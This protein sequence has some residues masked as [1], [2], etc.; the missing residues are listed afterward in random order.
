VLLL[1]QRGTGRSTPLTRLTVDGWSDVDIAAYP[2]HF[3]ADSIVRDA[4]VLRE[5]LAG[6]K[7]W[8]TIAQS[9]GGWVTMTYLS[10]APEG[11]DACY[12]FGGL[13]GLTATAD[14]V[15]A[16]TYPRVADKNAAYYARFP[17]DVTAVRRIADQLDAAE[18]L[19][20]DGDRLTTR[21]FRRL[22]SGFGMSYGYEQLHWVLDEAWHGDRLSDVF[23]HHVMEATGHVDGPLFPLQE[24]VYG[25]PGSGATAWAA[26]RAM[27]SRPEFADASDPLLFT[28]EMFY[29][30]MFEEVRALR[31]FRGAAELLA[32][33]DDWGPVYDLDR[34]AANDVPVLAVVYFD[35]M[36]VDSG[37]QLETARHVG[38]ARAWVT[39]EYEHDGIRADGARILGRLMDMRRGKI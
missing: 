32:A 7:K 6:G 1:D 9:Y 10:L 30:W 26:E 34:L 24:Y 33:E 3:R 27:A 8:E 19:L 16:R 25:Q 20:P 11:L 36:Y 23:L 12:V 35:D 14:D 4:E 18:V 5:R 38:N 22:G 31:P 13:P 17:E 21:R 2:R 28:G 29:P 39:N 37:L 15:Y